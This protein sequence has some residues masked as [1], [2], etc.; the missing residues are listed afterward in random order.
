MT[1]VKE[2]GQRKNSC[3][4]SF[5]HTIQSRLSDFCYPSTPFY[6]VKPT[7]K[8]PS[9][10]VHLLLGMS[11]QWM[12]VCVRV[13]VFQ[14]DTDAL[15]VM[16]DCLMSLVLL[17]LL[18]LSRCVI[19]FYTLATSNP[20]GWWF[21]F[22]LVGYCC[23]QTMLLLLY[24]VR[25]RREGNVSDSHILRYLLLLTLFSGCLTAVGSRRWR[26]WEMII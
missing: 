11:Q 6:S 16:T 2:R 10:D 13:F 25:R 21:R 14:G 24:T 3:G 22:Y 7:H 18:L 20:L 8:P 26:F 23:C 4:S 19:L 5:I 15:L 1:T 9:R 12:R 17:L